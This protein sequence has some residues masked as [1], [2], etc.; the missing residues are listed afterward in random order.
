[1][2]S[3]LK[4]ISNNLY[5]RFL[6]SQKQ[7]LIFLVL[8]PL[9]LSVSFGIILHTED[10]LFDQYIQEKN[11]PTG[12][13]D[14]KLDLNKTVHRN[15]S[16][17]NK[18]PSERMIQKTFEG[19]GKSRFLSSFYGTLS[20]VC[21]ITILIG[22]VGATLSVGNIIENG[23]I[24]YHI[25]NK[26]SREKAFFEAFSYPLPYLFFMASLGVL[27]IITIARR[28]FLYS[29]MF[30]LVSVSFAMILFSLFQGYI[31][32]FFFSLLLESKAFPIISG[33]AL[34]FALPLVEKGALILLPLRPIIL[35]Y[36]E[37]MPLK[38]LYPAVGICLLGLMFFI[39]FLIFKGRD[40]Y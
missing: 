31:F 38:A 1:M 25:V 22:V 36:Y 37:N 32:G 29:P 20:A 35:H 16:I 12:S 30:Y 13:G 34:I 8:I 21:K 18:G 4:C 26:R 24:V 19:A 40:P 11:L 5:H 23:S 10:N 33:L 39:S 14:F 9:V 7:F 15:E 3:A 27:S 28:P 17:Y 6:T 2:L